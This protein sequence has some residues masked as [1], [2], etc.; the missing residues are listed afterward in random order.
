MGS[1]LKATILTRKE[2]RLKDRQSLL[3]S[4][5]IIIFASLMQVYV[6]TLVIA[7]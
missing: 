7:K 6:H 3:E 1:Y 2:P 5:V 4:I